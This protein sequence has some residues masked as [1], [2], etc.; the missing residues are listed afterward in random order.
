MK[1]LS[2]I[3]FVFF[4][5]FFN[6]SLEGKIKTEGGNAIKKRSPKKPEPLVDVQELLADMIKKDE[7]LVQITKSKAGYKLATQILSATLGVVSAA[8][9][10]G[11]GLVMFNANRGRHPFKIG[12]SEPKN[13]DVDS[14]EEGNDTNEETSS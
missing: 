6:K 1:R 3:F 12:P 13:E 9:I 10:G 2:I 8:L 11:I 4:F 5:I 14:S 7:E